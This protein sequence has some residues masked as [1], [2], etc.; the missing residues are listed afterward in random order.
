MEDAFR[1]PRDVPHPGQRTPVTD[2]A[3]PPVFLPAETID[4]VLTRLD[5]VI[6]TAR[7]ERNRIGYFAALYRNVTLRVREGIARGDFEDGARMGRL[8]VAFANRYLEALHRFCAGDPINGCWSVAFEA[9]AHWRPVVLQHLLLGMNAH[10][11]LDLGVAAAVTCPGDALPGLRHDFE[12]INTILRAMLDEGQDR[13]A[14]I[15]PLLSLLDWIGCRTD[16]EILNFKILLARDAAWDLATTLAEL[17]EAQAAR[18]VARTDAWVTV[19]ARLIHRP[20]M[21]GTLVTLV[22]RAC[23]LRG[24]SRVI[25][26]LT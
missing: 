4:E 2:R 1:A 10:I 18:V 3:A 16:E 7:Q 6:A 19:L 9:A 14:R 26:A 22:I 11:N 17:D 23:E 12:V 21:L 25:D 15:W 8:D 5:A 20:G 13:L 24:V